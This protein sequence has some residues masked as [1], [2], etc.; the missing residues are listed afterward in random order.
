MKEKGPKT[1]IKSLGLYSH[2]TIGHGCFTSLKGCKTSIFKQIWKIFNPMAI[3]VRRI[4]LTNEKLHFL[5][6]SVLRGHL[7]FDQ[8]LRPFFSHFATMKFCKVE[9]TYICSAS[10]TTRKITKIL[11]PFGFLLELE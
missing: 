7:Y 8:C 2:R 3:N 5:R 9:F 6:Y 4:S 10:E 1:L 11:Q